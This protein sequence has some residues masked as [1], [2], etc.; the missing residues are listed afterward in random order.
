MLYMLYIHNMIWYIIYI[1]TA[2]GCLEEHL[3]F[4]VCQPLH[5][6]RG[7]LFIWESREE[8]WEGSNWHGGVKFPLFGASCLKYGWCC[9]GLLVSVGFCWGCAAYY[10]DLLEHTGEVNKTMMAFLLGWRSFLNRFCEIWLL[11]AARWSFRKL[12]DLCNTIE[13]DFH[14]CRVA[15]R[16]VMSKWCIFSK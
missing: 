2:A 6:E 8:L 1:Y 12:Q 14:K 9:L 4:T 16:K 3:F 10:S 13:K 11:V 5:Y 7:R 15:F